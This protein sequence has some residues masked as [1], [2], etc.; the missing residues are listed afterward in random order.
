VRST[1]SGA[2]AAAAAGL[3]AQELLL[4]LEEHWEA[5][6]ELQAVPIYQVCV[7]VRACV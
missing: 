5:H 7:C 4:M 3:R 2:A 6:P 1:R